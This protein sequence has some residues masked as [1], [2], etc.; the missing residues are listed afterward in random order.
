MATTLYPKSYIMER[1]AARRVSIES[2][3]DADT[4]IVADYKSTQVHRQK[5][6]FETSISKITAALDEY[7]QVVL[8]DN[9]DTNKKII[10]SLNSDIQAAGDNFP[11]TYQP[12][13]YQNGSPSA[14][15]IASA[16]EERLREY[17]VEL[18]ALDHTE[19]YLR[20]TP[21][22]EFSLTSLKRLGLLEAVRFTL[23]DATKSK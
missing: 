1:M 15:Q 21:V 16:A 20:D 19:A 14:D 4:K 3:R 17:A 11:R 7:G 13:G 22:D 12:Y 5:V 18:D 23:D 8:G 6:W 2:R 9:Y 10:G